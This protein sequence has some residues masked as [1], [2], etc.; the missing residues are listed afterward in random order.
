MLED[1]EACAKFFY[2]VSKVV[3]FS[4]FIRRKTQSQKGFLFAMMTHMK[5]D[6][7]K[8]TKEIVTSMV[9]EAC[10]AVE[11]IKVLEFELDFLK[12]SDVSALT[13]LQLETVAKRSVT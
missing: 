8:V 11:K 13:A 1:T 10:L 12:G 2:G 4:F 7:A 5:Q 9:A 3:D 6:N